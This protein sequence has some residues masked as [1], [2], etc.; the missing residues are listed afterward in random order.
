MV[1]SAIDLAFS[2]KERFLKQ[3]VTVNFFMP[4]IVVVKK[5]LLYRY[6]RSICDR[7]YSIMYVKSFSVNSLLG[8]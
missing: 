5:P 6:N 7:E 3:C 8:D 2:F 4:R 1:F